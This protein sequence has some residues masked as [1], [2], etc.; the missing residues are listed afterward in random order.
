M[1]N[2][3]WWKDRGNKIRDLKFFSLQATINCFSV[4]RCLGNLSHSYRYFALTAAATLKKS[5]N[6]CPNLDFEILERFFKKGMLSCSV[7]RFGL[8]SLWGSSLL[9][10]GVGEGRGG[11]SAI[12]SHTEFFKDRDAP[13]LSSSVRINLRRSLTGGLSTIVLPTVLKR[14]LEPMRS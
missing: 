13:G 11:L 9:S 8:Y 5:L 12:A 1:N 3:K 10:G 14:S 4:P 6:A 7:P 2:L